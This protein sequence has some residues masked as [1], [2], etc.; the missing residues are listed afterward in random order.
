MNENYQF[1]LKH[2]LKYHLFDIKE[3][4]FDEKSNLRI[5]IILHFIILPLS[6]LIIVENN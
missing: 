5:L 2:S 4:H 6:F 1:P 3:D